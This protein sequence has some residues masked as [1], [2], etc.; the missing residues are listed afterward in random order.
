[1][2]SLRTSGGPPVIRLSV[3]MFL[4]FLVLGSTMPIISLYLKI[5][6]GFSGLQ[7]GYILA[8]SAL[9]T[10]ASPF[11]GAL[12]ADRY[13]SAERLLSFTHA[14]GALILYILSTQT[15]FLPVFICHLSYWLLI[16]P[17]TALTTAIT[18]HHAPEAV[19]TFGGIRLWGTI[20]WIAAAWI[21]RLLCLWRQYDSTENLELALQLGVYSSLVLTLFALFIPRGAPRIDRPPTLLP[22]ESLAVILRKPVLVLCIF[23]GL[24]AIADRMYMFGGAPYL[25]SLGYRENNILPVLS[26]G[27]FPEILGMALLG[28]AILRFGNKKVLLLGVLLEIIRFI[29]FMLKVKGMVL[30]SSIGIHGLTYT[31]IFVTASIFLDSRCTPENRSGAHQYFALFVGGVSTLAGNILSGFVAELATLPGTGEIRFEQFWFVPLL[32]SIAGFLILLL[33]FKPDRQRSTSIR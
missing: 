18:F 29:L 5:K 20:G 12:I 3:M 13:I 9:S 27:Q 26:I 16:G 24:I 11:I 8:G 6:C 4:Q 7:I 33:F 17:T 30:Y 25:Q 21:Y 14:A 2:P 28:A 10:L 22:R 19:K 1:M 32:F 23:T 31:F 15:D